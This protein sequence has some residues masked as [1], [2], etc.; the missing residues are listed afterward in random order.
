MAT[1][2]LADATRADALP[3][4]VVLGWGNVTRSD[5][6]LGPL[7]LERIRRADLPHVA[8]VEDFQLQPEHAFDL[9]GRDLALFVDAGFETP[10]PFVFYRTAPRAGMAF[11][12]HKV[13]PEAV[14]D[15]HQRVLG[16]PPPAFV[17]SV[18]GEDF[19]VGDTLSAA[20]AHRL[21]LASDFLLHRLRSPTLENWLAAAHTLCARCRE[22]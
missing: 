16:P 11:S 21:E 4:V 18:A 3:R 7:L 1:A 8:V 19:S 10:A 5:D 22:G 9:S 14:L 20:A 13:A 2:A 12:S 17:L 6:A 15:L